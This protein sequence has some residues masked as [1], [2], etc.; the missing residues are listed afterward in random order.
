[1]KRIYHIVFFICLLSC[2]IRLTAQ[3]K[4]TLLVGVHEEAPF[5][6]KNQD[7]YSGIAIDLWEQ[8]AQESNLPYKYI[9]HSDVISILRALDY[10]ELDIAINPVTS[11]PVRLEKFD[12]TQPYY[13]SSVGVAITTSS[14][15]QF[16]LFINNFFS[17]DFLKV[18]LLLLII[19]LSFGTILW[20]VERRQNK[21]Q[22]RPGILGLFDGLWWAAVT[23]TTV[24]YGDKA[25]KTHLGKTIA[26]IWMFTAIIIISS[27]TATI[28]STLTVNTLEG[29]I[30]SLEDLKTIEKIG[31]VGASEGSD[32]VVNQQITPYEIYRTPLQ[33][34]RALARK[35][36]A[37]LIYNRTTLEYLIKTNQLEEN[38]RLLPLYFDAQYK[39]FVLS[40][41]HSAFDIINGQVLNT[42][43][44]SQWQEV[45]KSYNLK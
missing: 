29:D 34:L 30:T 22:F 32:F 8:V 24:G 13:I 17:R 21:Y 10:K 18:V 25:P 6:I 35:D 5:I 42:I 3:L 12:V 7:Q 4:D 40:K 23:M 39:S 44:N 33:G 20:G 26:I 19:L 15:S 16:Q 27:F 11:N 37:V 2:T 45:L 31:V 38:I 36:I 43:Q 1:M 28:A 9:S 14:Q 41:N